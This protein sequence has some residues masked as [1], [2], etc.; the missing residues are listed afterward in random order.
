M[1]SLSKLIKAKNKATHAEKISNEWE[2]RFKEMR[3]HRDALKI[4]L[5]TLEVI[6]ADKC[7]QFKYISQKLKEC[8]IFLK[9]E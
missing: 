2:K 3:A 7:V 5:K 1:S 9:N 6:H 4:K 8:R